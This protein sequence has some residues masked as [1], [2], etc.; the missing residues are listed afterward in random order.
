MIN[1]NFESTDRATKN[2]VATEVE[3]VGTY[4]DVAPILEHKLGRQ[5]VP[6]VHS[7]QNMEMNDFDKTLDRV[8]K[9]ATVSWTN[10][11]AA[12]V[13]LYTAPFPQSLFSQ[14]F[15]A[16]KINDFRYFVGGVRISIRMSSPRTAYGKILVVF[17]PFQNY[18]PVGS[19][20]LAT[21]PMDTGLSNIQQSTG[22]PHL[23]IDA[24][25]GEVVHW[26]VPYISPFRALDLAKYGNGEI[27]TFAFTVLNPLTNS[28]VATC[29]AQLIITASF[30]DAKVFMPN[31]TS[32]AAFALRER[33]LE[34]PGSKQETD[35]LN[36][37]FHVQDEVQMMAK[38][39]KAK[40]FCV[41][42]DN[43]VDTTVKSII[44]VVKLA[45]SIARATHM[46]GLSKPNTLNTATVMKTNCN[47]NMNN[48]NGIETTMKTSL[49]V[50][51]SISTDPNVVGM[52]VDEMNLLHI[53]QT[54]VLIN[55]ST[56]NPTSLGVQIATL[57]F[58]GS[59]YFDL[60]KAMHAGWCG[61]TKFKIYITASLFHSVRVVFY[62][63]AGSS[64]DW[65]V[66]YHQVVEIQGSTEVEMMV[67]FCSPTVSAWIIDTNPTPSYNLY[68]T[69]LAWSQADNSLS[70]PI[71]LNTYKAAASDVQF[72]APL[73]VKFVVQGE[74]LDEVQS[75][76]RDDFKK[77]FPPIESSV[78]GYQ[79]E[80]FLF[81]EKIGSVRELIHRNYPM[82][83]NGVVL[84]KEIFPSSYP[85][86]LTVVGPDMW[87]MFYRFYRGS[88]R[89]KNSFGKIKLVL[90]L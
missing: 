51:N 1:N 65:Q 23:L 18:Y 44:K 6:S 7:T 72:G 22:H 38:E 40:T 82:D 87:A 42:S 4:Q 79:Q 31:D 53:V 26:E 47:M 16:D 83:I 90:E 41:S 2:V 58:D 55:I 11:Q 28:E 52:G 63:A 12:G 3:N 64:A 32:T 49:D 67:P 46:I 10:S 8:F 81:G 80:N 25:A 39:A 24:S 86:G 62:V 60:V 13:L 29:S 68:C 33:H 34:Q 74:I 45:S 73:D 17:Y 61:S 56:L 5:I 20:S 88:I 15:I 50:S 75:S 37:E 69:V 43:D 78:T 30:I 9:I 21:Y 35:R 85:S 27:G 36:S 71:Y 70:N 54:P 59:N 48:G 66:C 89:A 77:E 19:G 76:P 57:G 14:T 84:S